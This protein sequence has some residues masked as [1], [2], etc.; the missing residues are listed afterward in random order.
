MKGFKGT[1][2]TGEIMTRAGNIVYSFV[3]VPYINSHTVC[4]FSFY[5]PTG[6]CIFLGT[7]L[8]IFM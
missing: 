8:G 6:T 1:T 7:R 4:H 2:R 3:L 5:W